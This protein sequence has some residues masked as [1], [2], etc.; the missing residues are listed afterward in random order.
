M[1]LVNEASGFE[2]VLFVVLPESVFQVSVSVLLGWLSW[3]WGVR[4]GRHFYR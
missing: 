1:I 2:D 4:S 3:K